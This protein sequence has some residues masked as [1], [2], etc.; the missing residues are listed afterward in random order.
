ML[1]NILIWVGFGIV[2]V[3][4]LVLYWYLQPRKVPPNAETDGQE[5]PSANRRGLDAGLQRLRM[6]LY[7]GRSMAY[8]RRDVSDAEKERQAQLGRF[9]DSGE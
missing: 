8:W 9:D 3:G 4:L 6:H 2:L 5:S 1:Y 7:G